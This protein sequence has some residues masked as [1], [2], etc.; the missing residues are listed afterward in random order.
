MATTKKATAE[1]SVS[2]AIPSFLQGEVTGV[3]QLTHSFIKPSVNETFY[4]EFQK[5]PLQSLV[6]NE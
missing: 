6:L 1:K 3:K 4:L 2:K 5:E